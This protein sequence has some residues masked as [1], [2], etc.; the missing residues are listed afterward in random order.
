M[1]CDTCEAEARPGARFCEECGAPL[2]TRCP[3]CGGRTALDKR[4]CGECGAALGEA[5]PR[6]LALAASEPPERRYATVLAFR[7]TAEDRIGDT[8][9][10]AIAQE[11]AELDGSALTLADRRRVL[12][13]GAPR[14]LE[15]HARQAVI[16]ALRVRDS[17]APVIRGLGVGVGVASGPISAEPSGW[18][19]DVE[20]AEAVGAALAIADSVEAGEIAVAATTARLLRGA[21]RLSSPRSHPVGVPQQHLPVQ[22]AVGAA[23]ARRGGRRADGGALSRFVGRERQMSTLEEALAQASAG[24]CQVV[25]MVGEPGMGKSRLLDEFRRLVAGRARWLEGRCLPEGAARPYSPLLDVLRDLCGLSGGEDAAKVGERVSGTCR[26]LGVDERRATYLI[27]LFGSL[28]AAAEE[29]IA[30][31]SRR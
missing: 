29:L 25:G 2:M 20:P 22:R 10:E 17:D 9:W 1:R 6:R 14:A 19:S 8:A 15:H 5:Q 30:H 11:I 7:S 28:E 26:R 18:E 4:F 23:P 3:A 12:V 24:T 21:V 16:A 31:L 13:F 27:H